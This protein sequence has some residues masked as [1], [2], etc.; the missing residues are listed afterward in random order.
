MHRLPV[1][2]QVSKD[3]LT[4]SPIGGYSFGLPHN[5]RQGTSDVP[6]RTLLMPAP[7]YV[8]PAALLGT[9][10]LEPVQAGRHG[11]ENRAVPVDPRPAIV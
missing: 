3:R 4:H 6:T 9:D 7:R 8:S 1:D 5:R 10:L 11:H 2:V